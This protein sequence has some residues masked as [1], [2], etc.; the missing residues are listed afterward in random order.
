MIDELIRLRGWS[1]HLQ[2]RISYLRGAG[3]EDNNTQCGHC[4]CLPVSSCRSADI[5]PRHDVLSAGNCPAT[6]P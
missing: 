5:G 2:L 1:M 6:G 3:I 4:A